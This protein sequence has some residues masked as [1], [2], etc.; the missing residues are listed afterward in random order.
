MSTI[1][2]A[3]G[4]AQ[5]FRADL[6]SG[7]DRAR[8]V[9]EVADGLGPVDILVNNAA[10]TFF[11]PIDTFPEKRFRLMVEVQLWGGLDLAQRVIPAMREKGRGWI[12]N[13][14]SRAGVNP[15]GPPY[16][17]FY[18]SGGSS[19][20]GLVKAGLDRLTTGMAAELYPDGIA[21]NALAPWDNVATPG[22]GAHDLTEGYR[23]EPVELMAQAALELCAS[24]PDRLT[25]RVAYSQPLLA[26][27]GAEAR[28]LDG[29]PL[30][31]G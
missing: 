17:A 16:E 26:E 20:Y 19:V 21:V 9:K 13:I 12:L 5:A 18:A 4:R 29:A 8:L 3:G 27:L 22:A 30:R 6:S 15:L 10:V 7:E 25:G 23:L 24:D 28:S 31:S 11:L 14:S 1:A 2:E